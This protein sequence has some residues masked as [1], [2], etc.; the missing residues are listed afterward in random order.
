MLIYCTEYC[1][2]LRKYI[3]NG[4]PIPGEERRHIDGVG[5]WKD[6]YCKV[7]QEKKRLENKIIVLEEERR[8][9]RERLEQNNDLANE[10]RPSNIRQMLSKEYEALNS[11]A[12]K[13]P[14]PHEE[15]VLFE[16]RNSIGDTFP[17]PSE[18]TI[19]KMSSYSMTLFFS[20]YI[21]ILASTLD[22]L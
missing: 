18:D 20:L 15:D 8:V 11:N 22:R 14:A 21:P 4:H 19:L 13:R 2:Q 9:M 12:R 7:H 3:K 16:A 10:E 5:F 6:Q 1:Q 17:S